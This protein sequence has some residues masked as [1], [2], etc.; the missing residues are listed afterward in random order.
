MDATLEA[1]S[2]SLGGHPLRYVDYLAV[3]DIYLSREDQERTDAN[4][5]RLIPTAQDLTEIVA[6]E[7][8]FIGCKSESSL[9]LRMRVSLF[10]FLALKFKPVGLI[11]KIKIGENDCDGLLYSYYGPS[12]IMVW[13]DNESPL[14]L[15][16]MPVRGHFNYTFHTHHPLGISVAS[17]ERVIRTCHGRI[18]F[19]H[20]PVGPECQTFNEQGA[21]VLASLK[22]L[23]STVFREMSG[24]MLDLG[25]GVQVALTGQQRDGLHRHCA[26]DLP[27]TQARSGAVSNVRHDSG[28][29]LMLSTA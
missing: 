5:E 4:L 12:R 24:R 13:K 7:D 11:L 8:I 10:R 9:A 2:R 1:V 15:E 27:S 29:E 22:R 28:Q 26:L 25:I 19:V 18:I 23:V 16:N 14:I 20:N 21:E 3:N 6:P 17:L